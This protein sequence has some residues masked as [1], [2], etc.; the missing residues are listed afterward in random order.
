VPKKILEI[1]RNHPLIANL[2]Q[3]LQSRPDSD[4]VDTAIEQL[5]ESALVQEG[6]HPNPVQMLPRIEQLMLLASAM[7][8]ADAADVGGDMGFDEEE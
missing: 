7:A 2:A 3:L 5:Y 6:L 1:N 4:L 8:N